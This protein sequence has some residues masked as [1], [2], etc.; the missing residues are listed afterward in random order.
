MQFEMFLFRCLS[1]LDALRGMCYAFFDFLFE[2]L[3]GI[4][5]TPDGYVFLFGSFVVYIV[6]RILLAINS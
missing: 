3:V 6:V 4:E 1:L 2:P 5:G